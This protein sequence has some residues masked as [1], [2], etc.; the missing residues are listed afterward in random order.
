MNCE[1]FREPVLHIDRKKTISKRRSSKTQ[2]CFRKQTF[3][4]HKKHTISTER[5]ELS[6]KP[7]EAN[8]APFNWD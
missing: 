1:F 5:D 8:Q 6:C 3:P 4:S 2:I 7:Q